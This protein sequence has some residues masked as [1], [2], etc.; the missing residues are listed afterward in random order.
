MQLPNYN[1]T[2]NDASTSDDSSAL[3]ITHNLNMAEIVEYVN[4]IKDYVA[5]LDGSGN[6]SLTQAQFNTLLDSSKSTVVLLAGMTNGQYIDFN[7]YRITHAGPNT[8]ISVA[9]VKYVI[10]DTDVERNTNFRKAFISVKE[11]AGA[12]IYP[13]IDCDLTSATIT[14]ANASEMSSSQAEQST[15]PNNKRIT[16]L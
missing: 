1:L 14:F 12:H 5:L 9:S 6:G 3:A 7:G 2:L 4:A 8:D 10:T 13:L 11:Y 16:I 15:D